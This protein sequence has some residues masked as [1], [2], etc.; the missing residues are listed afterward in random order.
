MNWCES[1]KKCGA[2]LTEKKR[3]QLHPILIRRN[4]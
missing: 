1:L 3:S 2:G 4:S